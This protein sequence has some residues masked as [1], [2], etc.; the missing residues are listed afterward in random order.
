MISVE[1]ITANT[2][3]PGFSVTTTVYLVDTSS[4]N[5]GITLPTATLCAGQ[6]IYFKKTSASNT[7]TITPYGSQTINGSGSATI[8]TNG[9]T[10]HMISDGDNWIYVS[11]ASD[12]SGS[13][14]NWVDTNLTVSTFSASPEYYLVDL[15]GG[16]IGITLPSVASNSGQLIIVKVIAD[17]NTLTITPNGS[18]TIADGAN[19]TSDVLGSIFYFVADGDNTDWTQ[20]SPSFVFT[21]SKA[22]VSDAD[23]NLTNSAASSTEVGYLQGVTSSIQTQIN[24]KLSPPTFSTFSPTVTLV[25]GAGNTTPVYTTNN[26]RYIEI[27]NFVFVDVLLDGDGGDEGAGT[28]VLNIALPTQA[29]T[30]NADYHFPCGLMLNNATSYSLFG[31]IASEAT[32]ISLSYNNAGTLTSLTGAEQ[33]STTRRIRLK[34]CYEK[35]SA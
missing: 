15:S 11:T 9:E 3:I 21:P 28:G 13:T 32:T 17:G 30:D 26:G 24:G 4:G 35:L 25:G 19:V 1:E 16:D 7:V 33:N 5:I 18:D 10:I 23:G 8:T 31:S 12:S 22:I 20:V 34:F 14:V 2:T 6:E 27:G 29:D